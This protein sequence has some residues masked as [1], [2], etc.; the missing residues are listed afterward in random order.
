MDPAGAT[1]HATGGPK[2]ADEDS[3]NL[4]KRI[5]KSRSRGLRTK[6]GC[7]TCRKRHKKC[8][9]RLPVCGPCSISSRDCVYAEGSQSVT[10]PH[11]KPPGAVSAVSKD[12]DDSSRISRETPGQMTLS[13]QSLVA[14]LP[15]EGP[16]QPGPQFPTATGEPY[17]YGYSP[18][19]VTSD[20]LTADLATTRWLDLL[21][22]DAA[23]ADGGFSL[24]PSPV[25]E[26]TVFNEPYGRLPDTERPLD[27]S[28][29]P[30]SDAV[31]T[32]RHAWQSAH[33]LPLEPHQA[34]LFR[35][36]AERASRWLDLF[37]PYKNF[38]TYATRLALRNIGLMRA[39]LA[40]AARHNA[41]IQANTGQ[42][43]ADHSEAIQYYYETLHYVQ[44]ALKFN[45]YA[46]S[47]ELLATTL[48]ISTYE[49]LDASDSNWQRH[50][51]GV[52]WIQRSQN[53]NGGSGGLRQSVWWA[54]LR[55]DLWAAFRERRRCFSF[56]RPVKDYPELNQDELADRAVY[57]LSQTVNYCAEP[58]ASS[59]DR[60]M[61]ERRAY[62]GEVLMT[63]LER[64]KTFLGPKFRPLPTAP[65]DSSVFE[66]L[67]IHPPQFAVAI[68]VYNF[69][70]ILIVLHRPA[71]AGFDGFMKT[72][73]MLSDAVATICGIAMEL[74]DEGCQILSAQCLFGAGLCAQEEVKRKTILYLVDAC[75]ART[76]WPMA[77]M[78]SDLRAEWA[79]V[80]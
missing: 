35:T 23:Q 75:E 18:E 26:D 27:S 41:M 43:G 79:K 78:R 2:P 30:V 71:I 33:D 74:K 14:P 39:I 73:R 51:K 49:M 46:H 12:S 61:V 11:G 16:K 9:E 63:M 50:L 17:Q 7:L 69:A 22:T 36:F 64:W 54:W 34:V 19:T 65:S 47:E 3:S 20:V 40:L 67:W 6:T 62:E 42:A 52:F 32:E 55:Q 59:T 31:L 10:I 66:P 48:V 80:G 58:H 4:K 57:L 76:G 72:Q 13:P 21:A 70:R 68:Q 8:D 38:S 45:S 25:P 44:T 1:T 56:W 5:R 15:E 28:G 24:A 60:Q 53:V 77:T 29:A 37:D